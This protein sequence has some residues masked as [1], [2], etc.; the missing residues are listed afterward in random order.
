[1]EVSHIAMPRGNRRVLGN[2]DDHSGVVE[3][4]KSHGLNM[5]CLYI[6][7]SLYFIFVHV[8]NNSNLKFSISRK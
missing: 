4:M 1:V 5:S 3:N 8:L 2:S 6:I 7:S